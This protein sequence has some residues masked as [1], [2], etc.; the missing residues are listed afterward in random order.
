[1]A[2]I[3]ALLAPGSLALLVVALC[4]G[5]ALYRA[6]RPR[7][8]RIW[9]TAWLAA[10]I[11]LSLPLVARGLHQGL[12]SGYP[13]LDPN[14]S[15]TGQAIVVLSGGAGRY[16]VGGEVADV[17]TATTALRVREA[18]RVYRMMPTS[19]VFVS[20]AGRRG[21]RSPEVQAMR[22]GL[23]DLGVPADRIALEAE[24]RDTHESAV[25]MRALF[26]AQAISRPVL[27]TSTQHM[28][29]SVLAFR[30]QGI[31]VVPAPAP[32]LP[33]GRLPLWSALLPDTS[34]LSLSE[35]CL[36]E[37]FGIAYYWLRGWA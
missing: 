13:T 14:S 5:L 24:S 30:A 17:M 2:I 3:K 16:L 33:A 32:M 28:R 4:A 20:G 37:Y 35:L 21:A 15:S 18:A 25:A 27:V 26:A 11:M 1:M 22:Q 8:G 34:G 9:M 19:M 36:H 12:A 7:A 10:Y 6:R 23:I 31:D 29:R